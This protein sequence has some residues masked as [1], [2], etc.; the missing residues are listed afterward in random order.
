LCF[1]LFDF[2]L[3]DLEYFLLESTARVLLAAAQIRFFFGLT[4]GGSSRP[5]APS[6]AAGAGSSFIFG[7]VLCTD[8]R[9]IFFYATPLQSFLFSVLPSL[10]RPVFCG[11]PQPGVLGESVLSE[12]LG[13]SAAHKFLLTRLSL[14]SPGAHVSLGSRI[15]TPQ[16]THLGVVFPSWYPLILFSSRLSRPVRSWSRA[17]SSPVCRSCP[18]ISAVSRIFFV[19][20]KV[21]AA[22][23]FPVAA[24]APR[25]LSVFSPARQRFVPQRQG[26]SIQLAGVLPVLI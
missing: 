10:S 19:T 20:M 23:Q 9:S 18:R 4:V 1:S 6:V 11:H 12:P 17:R 15:L 16:S 14:P 2:V 7:S 21:V 5:V 26:R 24:K 3:L 25:L 8:R 22:G 13:L